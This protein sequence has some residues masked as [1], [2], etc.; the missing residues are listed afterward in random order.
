MV[1]P[2]VLETAEGIQEGFT[3]E[4]YDRMQRRLRDR[5]W[6]ET[7]RI[8]R[9]GVDAGAVLEVGP[10]PGYLGLEWLKKTS[11]TTLSGL[12]ISENMIEVAE[13]NASEYGLTDRVSYVL[14]DAGEMPFGD[15]AFDAVFS[16]GSL[17]EWDQPQKI[18]DEIGRV[19]KPGGRY[20]V[21]DLRRDMNPLVKTLMKLSTK[22]KEIRPGLVTSINAAYTRDELLD[23]LSVTSLWGYEVNSTVMGLE[24]T[25]EKP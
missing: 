15:S 25:G 11:A 2:R 18:F 7:D 1:R 13:K 24:I 4:V 12:E 14:G 8:I 9:S 21:S 17:H 16:N 5:G 23:L 22:P 19:L 20:F 6:M 10:G 3:V